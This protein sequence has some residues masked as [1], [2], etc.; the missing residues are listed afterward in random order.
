MQVRTRHGEGDRKKKE[1][2]FICS[3]FSDDYCEVFPSFLRYRQ[4]SFFVVVKTYSCLV[5]SL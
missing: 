3:S 5:V 1:E 2:T 4:C